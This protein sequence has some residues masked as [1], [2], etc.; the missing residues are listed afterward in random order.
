MNATS[1]DPL[2]ETGEVYYEDPEN[3]LDGTGD[4]GSTA[5]NDTESTDDSGTDSGSD[6]LTDKN[7]GVVTGTSTG[8][9]AGTV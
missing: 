8:T 4:S 7:T 1:S 9:A 6:S 2:S 3:V 5:A